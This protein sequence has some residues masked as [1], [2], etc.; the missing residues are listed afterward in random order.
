[1]TVTSLPLA[2]AVGFT[3]S[4]C[5][6][7]RRVAHRS[8]LT[9]DQVRRIA[10]RL[11]HLGLARDELARLTAHE[12]SRLLRRRRHRHVHRCTGGSA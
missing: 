3:T 10:R 2:S 6:S 4:T 8:Q 12:L 5:L 11:L 9:E 1:M 7:Q